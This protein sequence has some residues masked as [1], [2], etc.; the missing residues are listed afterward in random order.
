MENIILGLILT[1]SAVLVAWLGVRRR[2]KL[3][4]SYAV[5]VLRYT[6]STPM[7]IVDLEESVLETWEER[8]DGS[9]ELR[10]TKVY[11]PTYEYTVNGKT[12]QYASRQ[13][14]SGLF[15]G[16]RVTGYYDPADPSCITENKPRK[17][18][19]G[20][21]GYFACAVFLLVFAVMAFAGE[22]YIY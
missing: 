13:S 1:L 21:F 10:Q 15:V 19:L 12:Y 8:D 2:K 9:R 7:T 4:K 17:P 18:V 22:V 14:S 6:A 16:K 20:G 11:A 5:D 3:Q